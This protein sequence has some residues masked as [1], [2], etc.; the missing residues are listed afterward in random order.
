M[1]SF[2]SS[3]LS[4]FFFPFLPHL[5][6][7]SCTNFSSP[8]FVLRLCCVLFPPVHPPLPVW[9]PLHPVVRIPF[10]GPSFPSPVDLLWGAITTGVAHCQACRRAS[11][12]RRWT[13]LW[14]LSACP[15][16]SEAGP[17][18]G[19]A[20]LR[21]ELLCPWLP[22]VQYLGQNPGPWEPGH[23][24]SLPRLLHLLLPLLQGGQQPPCTPPF[25][26]TPPYSPQ[27]ICWPTSCTH[28]ALDSLLVCHLLKAS[29]GL[30]WPLFGRPSFCLADF[31]ADVCLPL[32][33]FA[34]VIG[35]SGW[36]LFL[37]VTNSDQILL[38]IATSGIDIRPHWP[39]FRLVTRSMCPNRLS[40]QGI[41]LGRQP[42]LFDEHAKVQI[43]GWGFRYTGYETSAAYPGVTRLQ[44]RC[45]SS[46]KCRLLYGTRVG[47]YLS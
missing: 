15:W 2:L 5:P 41:V 9:C 25:F 6:S 26:L 37:A 27:T 30:D 36:L 14:T 10:G 44:K 8:L 1:Y 24:G 31:Q 42:M 11:L 23:C 28:K 47:L 20:L 46:V 45:N 18:R 22:H 21:V 3:F 38:R 4:H 39:L 17:R 34:L 16:A 43:E 7:V 33:L 13:R 29:Q 19:A 35:G 32:L 12:R 40:P